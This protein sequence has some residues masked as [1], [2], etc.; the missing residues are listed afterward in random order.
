MVPT[1]RS[2]WGTFPWY[3]ALWIERPTH[4]L[5]AHREIWQV[6]P[7]IMSLFGVGL[8]AWSATR[9]AGRWAAAWRAVAL[10]C[11]GPGLL[12]L[13]FAWSMHAMDVLH[14]CLLGACLVWWADRGGTVGGPRRHVLL[15][16]ALAAVT[17]TGVASDRLLIVAGLAPLTLAGLA[18]PWLMS[19]RAG[20]RV[21]VS[22]ASV[23]AASL[24]LGLVIAKVMR[25]HDVVSAHFPISYATFE[26][27]VPNVST[28]A[29]G[30]AW[31]F[32]GDF[33]GARVTAHSTLAFAC[34]VVVLAGLVVAY[35]VVRRWAPAVRV[36]ELP[37]LPQR[38]SA[39][40]AYVAFWAWAGLLPVIAYL[41][42]S[43]VVNQYTG[44]YIVTTGYAVAALVPLAAA[45]RGTWGRAAAV[46]GV[47][48]VVT[49]SIAALVRRDL[50]DNPFRFPTG[51]V[52][53]PLLRFAEKE[54]L[55]VG[56]AGYWDAAPLTWQMKA[57]VKVYPVRACNLEPQRPCV[58][59]FHKISSWYRPRPG[60]RSFLVLDDRQRE[61]APNE[62]GDFFGRPQRRV[63]LGYLT[64]L[65]YP[66]DIAARF[67][68]E[69][70]L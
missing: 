57:Q 1:P 54:G 18:M 23:A 59:P 19:R 65:V 62:P 37:E 36:R 69:E 68:P 35:R 16:A 11:A 8:V 9:V 13:Q 25:D 58:F 34:A 63:R 60:T 22:S 20:I 70:Q 26:N 6:A 30:M 10:A 39:L 38:S 4:G 7:W 56:Y 41:V 52:S 42:S 49:G 46:A 32:N 45:A 43:L 28:F 15:C 50:Q 17:A 64:V 24:V 12:Q 55:T 21:A 61:Q 48:V 2:S 51:E 3:S 5:P 33:S 31:L 40:P 67:G 66:Y 29:H 53:G 44:R 14:V 27:L 47:C